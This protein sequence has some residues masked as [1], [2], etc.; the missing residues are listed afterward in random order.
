MNDISYVIK[1]INDT[2]SIIDWPVKDKLQLGL[3]TCGA[4]LSALT[5]HKVTWFYSK[6]INA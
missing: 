4:L 6:Q 2:T 3:I 5:L 1:A